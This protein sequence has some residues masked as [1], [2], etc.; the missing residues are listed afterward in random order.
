MCPSCCFSEHRQLISSLVN[1]VEDLKAEVARLKNH[2]P[3]SVSNLVPL[4][5]PVSADSNNT[6]CQGCRIGAMTPFTA[7]GI[8]SGRRCFFRRHYNYM[9]IHAL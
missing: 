5:T 1:S 8:A 2:V 3:I 9:Y 6:A 7:P 4:S